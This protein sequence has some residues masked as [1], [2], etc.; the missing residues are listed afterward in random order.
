[1]RLAAGLVHFFKLCGAI[2]FVVLSALTAIQARGEWLTETFVLGLIGAS[3]IGFVVASADSARKSAAEQARVKARAAERQDFE[4]NVDAT[5]SHVVK[6]I[7]EHAV[8]GAKYEDTLAG[9]DNK[10]AGVDTKLSRSDSYDAIHEI[11]L[12]LINDNRAMQAKV[13][14]LSE[15]LEHSRFQIVRLRSSLSKAEEIGNR[16][17]LT[18]LG[19]RRFFDN[20]LAQEVAKARDFGGELCVALA[21][22]DHFKKINDKY[23]HGAGDMVLKLFADLLT[24]NV[25][26][27]DKVAR[28]GGEEFAILFPDSRLADAAAAV[29]AIQKQLESK[30]WALAT[31]GER[32]GAITASFGLARL[33]SDET[34]EDLVRRADVKLYEAKASGRNRVL[35]D[36]AGRVEHEVET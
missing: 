2:L 9:V 6:L 24:A 19:N 17:G 36:L 5:L 34:A 27:H 31:T 22:I 23:G 16:D 33:Q 18:A 29:N 15:K 35:V 1:M 3:I 26:R 20:V 4:R 12:T 30:Q 21:D 8:E 14:A 7:Q 32:I 25:R 28:F 13:T 10:L 11:V